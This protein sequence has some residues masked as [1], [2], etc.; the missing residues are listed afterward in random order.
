[1]NCQS[2][3]TLEKWPYIY[4]LKLFLSEES[5]TKVPRWSVILPRIVMFLLHLKENW[6]NY[7]RLILNKSIKEFINGFFSSCKMFRNLL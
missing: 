6:K 3:H 1:M 5:P 2:Y 4:S 7:I